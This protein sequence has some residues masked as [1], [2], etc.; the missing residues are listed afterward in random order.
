MPYFYLDTR[1]LCNGE[2]DM[3]RSTCP[4]LPRMKDRMELGYFISGTEA[5]E[6]IRKKVPGA[7]YCFYCCHEWVKNQL[8]VKIP[9]SI[10]RR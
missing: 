3:H 1:P 6:Q 7:D 2:Y 4:H 10:E 9:F 8:D 5:L